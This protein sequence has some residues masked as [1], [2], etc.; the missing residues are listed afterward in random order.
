VAGAAGG[1][2]AWSDGG[3]GSRHRC[4]SFG[5]EAGEKGEPEKPPDLNLD[6]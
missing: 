3:G 1:G 4:S 5:R 6:R 2:L